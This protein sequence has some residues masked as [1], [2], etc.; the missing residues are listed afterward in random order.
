M[1]NYYESIQ[2]FVEKQEIEQKCTDV[3][4]NSDFPPMFR[5]YFKKYD[6]VGKNIFETV[7]NISSFETNFQLVWNLFHEKALLPKPIII[8]DLKTFKTYLYYKEMNRKMFFDKILNEKNDV[9]SIS[10]ASPFGMEIS[11][12]LFKSILN[13]VNN[14][15][16]RNVRPNINYSFIYLFNRIYESLFFKDNKYDNYIYRLNKKIHFLFYSI[17][18][19]KKHEIL[20]NTY[21]N[22]I[23]PQIRSKQKKEM[24]NSKII[25]IGFSPVYE[26]VSLCND[27]CI[28]KNFQTVF[29]NNRENF[30]ARYYYKDSCKFFNFFDVCDKVTCFL[31][32][33]DLFID[34][35]L[36][37]IIME[38]I[39]PRPYSSGISELNYYYFQILDHIYE[40]DMDKICLKNFITK[41]LIR[42]GIML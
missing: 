12:S 35:F 34:T 22:H 9:Y 36:I 6:P 11:K 25:A 29:H 24:H 39:R 23:E 30:V 2:E 3:I 31:K 21:K 20:K 18:N 27:L 28:N 5:E 40:Y 17:L 19:N 37:S 7:Y 42:K 1:L 38:K 10:Y 26:Y 4:D 13:I 33:K 15:N 8:T 41:C 32:Y 16:F 14:I